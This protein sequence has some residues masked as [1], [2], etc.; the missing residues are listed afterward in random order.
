MYL[1]FSIHRVSNLTLNPDLKFKTFYIEKL[2]ASI[3]DS[4]NVCHRIQSL[5]YLSISDDNPS[6]LK[7]KF[8]VISY[9]NDKLT[10]IAFLS[11]YLAI[12]FA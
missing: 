7:R 5:L 1:K 11:L 2:I 9:G 10:Y 6:H 12:F 4:I 3:K 8:V